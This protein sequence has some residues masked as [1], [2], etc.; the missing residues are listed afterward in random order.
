MAQLACRFTFLDVLLESEDALRDILGAEMSATDETVNSR[1]RGIGR[2]S[3][4]QLMQRL[5]RI[6]FANLMAMAARR[7]EGSRARLLGALQDLRAQ[8]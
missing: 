3:L 2:G 6:N 1:A 5:R 8:E 7:C 4:Q